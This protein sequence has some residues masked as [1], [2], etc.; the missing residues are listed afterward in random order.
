MQ[1]VLAFVFVFLIKNGDYFMSNENFC[2]IFQM[3]YFDIMYHSAVERLRLLMINSI[4]LLLL[5]VLCILML[6]SIIC[7]SSCICLSSLACL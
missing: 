7:N 2:F 5:D 1:M 3:F 4:K 6:S